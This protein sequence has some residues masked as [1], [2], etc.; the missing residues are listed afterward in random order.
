MKDE[1]GRSKKE[2]GIGKHKLDGLA[3]HYNRGEGFT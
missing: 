2:E 1:K 3:P